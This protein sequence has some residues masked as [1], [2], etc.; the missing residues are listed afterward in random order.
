MVLGLPAGRTP[1]PLYEELV[2][3]SRKGR[4][5]VSGV[6]TFNLDEFVGVSPS[7]PGSY[8][9]FMQRQLFDHVP[10]PER[11]RHM[12]NGAARDTGVECARYERAIVRAGGID[13]QVLGL[14]MNGHIGF[15]EPAS[16][17]RARTHRTRL[18]SSSRYANRV[19]FGNDIR[20]VPRE[21]LSMGMATILQ[22]KRIVVMATGKAKAACVERMVAGAVTTQVPASLLQLHRNVEVWLDVQ[23]ASRLQ[24][25]GK[26]A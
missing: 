23:A 25:P 10:I 2:E 19:L 3:L 26:K 6:T 12:L 22:A 21:A 16:A 14:G 17:L 1:I 18:T 11:R 9:S 20:K 15:N 4:L 8:R 5:D 24:R 7:H 13:L